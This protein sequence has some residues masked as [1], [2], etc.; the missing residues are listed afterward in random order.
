MVEPIVKASATCTRIC[1]AFTTSRSSVPNSLSLLR[2]LWRLA[3]ASPLLVAVAALVWFVNAR[4]ASALRLSDKGMLVMV[5]VVRIQLQA[6]PMGGYSK[7]LNWGSLKVFF[8]VSPECYVLQGA[9]LQTYVKSL[10]D[11]AHE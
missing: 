4:D 5:F 2:N 6:S 10:L 11:V 3:S 1:T 8:V 9:S 7:H